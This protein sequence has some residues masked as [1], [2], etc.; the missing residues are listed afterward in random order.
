MSRSWHGTQHYAP[1]PHAPGLFDPLDAQP[2]RPFPA[3]APAGPREVTPVVLPVAWD[4]REEAGVRRR[5][6]R[7]PQDHAAPVDDA[8]LGR[9]VATGSAPTRVIEV[10]DLARQR[11][12]HLVLGRRRLR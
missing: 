8:D 9:R 11:D 6:F 12:L 5:A 4:A 10:E 2:L 1:R 3:H 7:T